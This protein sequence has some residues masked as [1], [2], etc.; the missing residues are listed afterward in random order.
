[1]TDKDFVKWFNSFII[2][3]DKLLAFELEKVREELKKIT[4]DKTVIINDLNK[5]SLVNKITDTEFK[6][7]KEK[8]IE[9]PERP[10]S[11]KFI[12][13]PETIVFKKRK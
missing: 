12:E 3:K 11:S 5:D 13:N 10:D 4:T 2:G 6:V 1:M 7:P 9:F 8:I